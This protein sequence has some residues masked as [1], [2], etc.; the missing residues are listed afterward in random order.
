[1]PKLDFT[2]MKYPQNGSSSLLLALLPEMLVMLLKEKNWIIY[3][4][5]Q[6]KQE[7]V[8]KSRKIG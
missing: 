6:S 2:S 4:S 1:M 5:W 3:N 8:K 7:K